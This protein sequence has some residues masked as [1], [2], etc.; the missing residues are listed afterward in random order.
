MVREMGEATPLLGEIFTAAMMR[1]ERIR[2]V[3]KGKP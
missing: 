2:C 3:A 1:H